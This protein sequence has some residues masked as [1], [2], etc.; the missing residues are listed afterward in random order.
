MSCMGTLR[1]FGAQVMDCVVVGGCHHV[2]SM[3][4]ALL[5]GSALATNDQAAD[6]SVKVNVVFAGLGIIDGLVNVLFTIWVFPL[7]LCWLH[8]LKNLSENEHARDLDVATPL[9]KGWQGA[10]RHHAVRVDD[11]R[12]NC[13]GP[14]Q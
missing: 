9:P 8:Q 5:V 3:F 2:A 1:M 7:T 14:H 11:V 4:R 10:H 13:R 6:I 12:G